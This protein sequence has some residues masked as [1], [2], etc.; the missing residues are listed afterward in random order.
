MDLMDTIYA[1]VEGTTCYI[2]G[3][4]GIVTGVTRAADHN[5][6]VRPVAAFV[7]LDERDAM[8]Y[9]TLGSATDDRGVHHTVTAAREIDREEFDRINGLD[10]LRR[11]LGWAA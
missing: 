8:L 5:A 11:N 6:H 2:N 4:R 3:E 10:T 1:E 7:K 9:L